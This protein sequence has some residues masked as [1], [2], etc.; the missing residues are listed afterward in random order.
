MAT[1]IAQNVLIF[2]NFFLISRVLPLNTVIHRL[3]TTGERFIMQVLMYYQE[4]CSQGTP[5]FT[6]WQEKHVFQPAMYR[7]SK[8]SR[9][10]FEASYLKKLNL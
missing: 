9:P 5:E 4:L 8:K 1:E 6:T 10:I 7:V 2:H 3:S